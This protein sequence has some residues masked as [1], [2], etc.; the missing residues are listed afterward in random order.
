MIEHNLKEDILL[1]LRILSST[2]GCNQRDLSGR[3]GFSL[4]KTNYLLKS[5]VEKGFVEIKNF[6]TLNNK[7]K[8]V[9]YMLTPRGFEHKVRLAYYFFKKKEEEYLELKK[10][11][12]GAAYVK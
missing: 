3:L 10:E 6:T 7:L 12:E 11:I 9:N 8:K 1:I 4:G 5:L 2:D